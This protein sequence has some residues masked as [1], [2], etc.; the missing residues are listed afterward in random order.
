ML[1]VGEWL[2]KTHEIADTLQ[3]E[4][5]IQCGK[6]MER[7]TAYKDGYVQACEDYAREMRHAISNNQG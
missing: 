7:A 2:D 3:R 1:K 6:E 4:A 5:A